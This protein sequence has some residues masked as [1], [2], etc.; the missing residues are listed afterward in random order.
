MDA[1]ERIFGG[2]GWAGAI[3]LATVIVAGVMHFRQRIPAWRATR[4]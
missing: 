1:I 2:D 4:K 3:L